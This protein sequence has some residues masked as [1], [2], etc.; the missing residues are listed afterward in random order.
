MYN[1]CPNYDVKPPHRQPEEDLALLL[2]VAKAREHLDFDWKGCQALTKG[3]EVLLGEHGRGDEHGHLLAVHHRLKSGPQGDLRLAIADVTADQ[4]VHRAGALHVALDLSQHAQLVLRLDIREAGFQLLLPGVVLAE[5]MPG[6][7][8]PLGVQL[9]Q[10]F[11]HLLDGLLDPRLGIAPL[12]ASQAT[13]RWDAAVR[14]EV[15]RQPVGLMHGHEELVSFGVLNRQVLALHA[16]HGP[17]HQSQEAPDAV[18]DVHDPVP[19]LQI[20]IGCFWGLDRAAVPAAELRPA[21]AEDLPIGEQMHNW[22]G[23]R[24]QDPA[25]RK[26]A[27]EEDRR[28]R[29]SDIQGSLLREQLL[30]PLGLPGND[31]QAISGG[32][33][34]G[35]VLQQRLE[36]AAK[37]RF[38]A[39]APGQIGALAR[40][41]RSELQ[42][43]PGREGVLNLGPGQVG[44]RE[45]FWQQTLSHQVGAHAD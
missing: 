1:V 23:G 31:H 34:L 43:R 28:G 12:R 37:A 40:R 32:S 7:D 33:S 21:P 15:L 30:Q 27:V 16:F 13:G 20:G 36:P 41:R 8:L 14:A 25:L 45:A 18:I 19:D 44:Q 22:P 11:S 35:E 4:P 24:G 5:G 2:G 42:G 9:E 38:G 39:E 26:A 6:H 3:V 29:W 10:V 17:V